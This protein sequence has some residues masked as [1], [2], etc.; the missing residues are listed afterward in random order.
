MPDERA[1]GVATWAVRLSARQLDLN[2]VEAARTALAALDEFEGTTRW[3]TKFRN[4]PAGFFS[5]H[6]GECL[7]LG[8][9]IAV[10]QGPPGSLVFKAQARA[11]AVPLQFGGPEIVACAGAVAVI[12]VAMRF[13]TVKLDGRSIEI[14][15]YPP[16]PS[17]SEADQGSHKVAGKPLGSPFAPQFIFIQ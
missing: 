8:S 2:I 16:D 4:D 13:R 7:D 9:I 17:V 6:S 5:D 3:S 1:L 11:T 12:L 10:E 14:T 15:A